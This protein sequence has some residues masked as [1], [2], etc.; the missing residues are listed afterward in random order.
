MAN[1]NQLLF[2]ALHPSAAERAEVAH[3]LLLSLDGERDADVDAEWVREIQRRADEVRS[4]TA[5]QVDARE[6]VRELAER[7]RQKQ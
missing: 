2:D 5:Q 7:L 6:A 4:G 1:K 3:E